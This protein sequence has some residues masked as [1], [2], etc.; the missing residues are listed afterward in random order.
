M[1][2]CGDCVCEKD[3]SEILVFVSFTKSL[4]NSLTGLQRSCFDLGC[5]SARIIGS[6]FLKEILDQSLGAAWSPVGVGRA[7]LASLGLWSWTFCWSPPHHGCC[8]LGR[9]QQVSFFGEVS[10]CLVFPW[11]WQCVSTATHLAMEF[12]VVSLLSHSVHLMLSLCF[13]QLSSL[14][15]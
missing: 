4:C 13:D 8:N 2:C 5:C 9:L 7:R 11:C 15:L 10:A 1:Q 3:Q 14:N 6:I 12:S